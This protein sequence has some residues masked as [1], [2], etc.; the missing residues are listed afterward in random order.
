MGCASNKATD[1][2]K[3]RAQDDFPTFSTSAAPTDLIIRQSL[4]YYPA[5]AYGST[6][7]GIVTARYRI[8]D[9]GYAE[10]VQ[11]VESTP[12]GV[13]DREVRSAISKWR[14]KPG[15]PKNNVESRISFSPKEGPKFS[16]PP[17][18]IKTDNT[19]TK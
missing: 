19:Y 15:Y 8:T 4:P 2:Q 7:S 11:I 5:K 14:F 17:V 9:A 12:P 18:I 1:S 13:F 10:N 6:K 3:A 16:G